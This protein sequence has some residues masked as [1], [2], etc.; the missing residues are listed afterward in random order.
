MLKRESFS[1]VITPVLVIQ[2]VNLSVL[3]KIYNAVVI[4][5]Q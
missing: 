5:S 2:E 1:T 3:P 4:R